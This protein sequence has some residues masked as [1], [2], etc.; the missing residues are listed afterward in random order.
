MPVVRRTHD[1]HRNLRPLG[2][3]TGTAAVVPADPEARIMIRHDQLTIIAPHAMRRP[4]KPH[5]L[6]DD[7]TGVGSGMITVRAKTTLLTYHNTS[8]SAA[9]ARP[10]A[11]R[12]YPAEPPGSINPRR[13]TCWN[14][15]F[16]HGRISYASALNPSPSLPFNISIKLPRTRHSPEPRRRRKMGR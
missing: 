2:A 4:T 5:A 9:V 16:L 10:S 15:G 3:T 7:C 1:R 13:V 12:S 14:R 6:G 8:R 11:R